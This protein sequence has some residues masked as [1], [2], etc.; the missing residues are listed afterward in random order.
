MFR[1]FQR[2]MWCFVAIKWYKL[3]QI[4]H[5][6]SFNG[7]TI[8]SSTFPSLR[9]NVRRDFLQIEWL[10]WIITLIE[11]HFYKLPWWFYHCVLTRCYWHFIA[12]A[13]RWALN[14]RTPHLHYLFAHPLTHVNANRLK[15]PCWL[16]FNTH[17]KFNLI[18]Y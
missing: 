4:D 10:N 9:V 6:V 17:H 12:C 5:V 11:N 16:H 15:F 8:Q 13:A 3:P 2:N 18:F 7:K 14:T 1:W